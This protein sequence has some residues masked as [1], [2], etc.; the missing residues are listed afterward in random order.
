MSKNGPMTV[1]ISSWFLRDGSHE[2]REFDLYNVYECF[3]RCNIAS[4]PRALRACVARVLRRI[5]LTILRASK[6]L[7]DYTRV[8]SRNTASSGKICLHL[9]IMGL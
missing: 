8:L 2:S 4:I 9:I 7:D 1:P 6:Y 3:E 5:F